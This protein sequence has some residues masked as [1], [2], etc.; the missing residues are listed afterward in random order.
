MLA[1]T[2]R[3]A[4]S[5]FGDLVAFVDPD[6]RPLTYRD[7]DRRSDAVAAGLA[8]AGV[9]SGDRVALRL[10]SDTSY[11]IS[12]AAAAKLG[13]ITAGINPR[14]APPEQQALVELADPKVVL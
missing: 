9:G 3:A 10:P 4:A 7:L 14:L 5:R 12:Y 8:A 11:V 2:V 1:A 6:G 13:A